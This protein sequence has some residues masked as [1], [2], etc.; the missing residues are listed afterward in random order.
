M[1]H[2]LFRYDEETGRLFWKNKSHPRSHAQI[3][4]EVGTKRV[5]GRHEIIVKGHHFRTHRVIWF[6][7]NGVWPKDEIDHLD[8]DP[9]N[10]R[11][12]NLRE[13]TRSENARNMRKRHNSQVCMNGVYWQK[14]D[15]RYQVYI[16]AGG[17]QK[18]LGYFANLDDACAARRAA[19]IEYGYSARHGRAA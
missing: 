17:R 2:H 12:D 6:M 7:A 14:R 9:S 4:S 13:A 18:Y 10:N 19:E 1:A 3:G 8:G 15:G 5:D 11:L 16:G